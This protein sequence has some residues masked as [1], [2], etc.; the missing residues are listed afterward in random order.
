MTKRFPQFVHL[1]V[2]VHSGPFPFYVLFFILAVS[3]CGQC[4][5]FWLKGPV[6]MHQSVQF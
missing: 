4:R 5:V 6:T 2:A 3:Q 1:V